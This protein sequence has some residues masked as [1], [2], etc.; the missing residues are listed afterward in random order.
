MEAKAVAKY[1]RMS[2][3]KLKPIA[4]LVRGKDLNEALNIL[5][6]TPGKGSEIV[7]KV[8]MSAAANAENNFDL[9]PEDLYVAEV[10][11]NQ[12]PTM[13]RWRAGAQGRASM[14]LKR[15]SHVGVTLKEKED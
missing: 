4:D 3:S 15:S 5:K 7:E 13:K 2:P 11:A 10:Y 6:F 12:G 1:V 9:N 8:V 14:I